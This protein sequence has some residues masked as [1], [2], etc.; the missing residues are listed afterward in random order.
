M[1]R[2]FRSYINKDKLSASELFVGFTTLKQNNFRGQLPL[3]YCKKCVFCYT[4][5]MISTVTLT[6]KKA[7]KEITYFYFDIYL[8]LKYEKNSIS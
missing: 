3:H 6:H 1:K 8:K 4:T 2:I 5:N 7:N